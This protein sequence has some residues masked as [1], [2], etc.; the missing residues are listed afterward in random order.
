[1]R[2][3]VGMDM[4]I[5]VTL[6]ASVGNFSGGESIVVTAAVIDLD[7]VGKA[8]YAVGVLIVKLVGSMI[9]AASDSRADVDTSGWTSCITAVDLT[10][11]ATSFLFVITLSFSC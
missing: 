6:E 8:A 7:F 4:S 3:A 11:P 2:A 1:M 9:V 10:L 5:A